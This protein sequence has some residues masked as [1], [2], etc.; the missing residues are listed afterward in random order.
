MQITPIQTE[1]SPQKPSQQRYGSFTA[2]ST[3]AQTQVRKMNLVPRL[4][5]GSHQADQPEASK[6]TMA[7]SSQQVARKQPGIEVSPLPADESFIQTYSQ[8]KMARKE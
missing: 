8:S 1:D 4:S 2:N 5:I 7:S 6:R 3:T